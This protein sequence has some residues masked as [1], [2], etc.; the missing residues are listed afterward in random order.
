M[1]GAFQ[2]PLVLINQNIYKFLFTELRISWL[3]KHLFKFKYVPSR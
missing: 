1:C 2:S 3:A